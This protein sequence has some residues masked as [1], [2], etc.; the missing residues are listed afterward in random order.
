MIGFIVLHNKH[1]LLSIYAK[2]DINN[3]GNQY[4]G[5]NCMR[6]DVTSEINQ[7]SK[8]SEKRIQPTLNGEYKQKY[9][10]NLNQIVKS[11]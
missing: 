8:N 11:R 10:G 3:I 1:T 2:Y 7:S 4:M 9:N 5:N 6:Q